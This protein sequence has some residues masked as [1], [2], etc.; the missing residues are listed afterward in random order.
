MDNRVK[1]TVDL[2]VDARKTRSG[3]IFEPQVGNTMSMACVCV[4][5]FWTFITFTSIITG[6]L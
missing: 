6:T 2:K 3:R 5:M 4:V 1:K